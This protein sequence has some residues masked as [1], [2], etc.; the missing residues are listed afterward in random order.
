MKKLLGLLLTGHILYGDIVVSGDD[1]L[2]S[3]DDNDIEII[4]T[5]EH[6][7]EAV[8]A[9]SFEKEVLH[10]YEKSYGFALDS[11]LHLGLLSSHNQIANAFSTQFPLNIQMNYIA[12][13]YMVDYMSTTSWL[14]TL[15]FHESAHNF[16]LNP[17]KNPLSNI[18]HKVVKNIPFTSLF[19]MP[20]FPVPNALE[21]SFMLEGNAVLN[22]S[23]FGNGGR[24][25]NGSLLAMAITQSYAG[26]ITPKRTYNNHLYFPYGAHH[27]IVGGFF[28]L[29]L[30]KKYGV[31]KANKYF[32]NFSGQ[33]LPIQ[34]S[35]IF[36][37]TF[38]HDYAK[39]LADYSTWLQSEYSE[40]SVSSGD[41]I[42]TSQGHTKLN[43]NKDE[44]FFLT[45]D[46]LS[47]PKLHIISKTGAVQKS[48]KDYFFNG[49][50]FKIEDEYF[51]VS[52]NHTEVEKI[53]M[54]LYD[55]KGRAVENSRSKIVQD[56]LSDGRFAYFDVGKSFDQPA[57]Y[58]G[59]S[60]YDYVN[61]SVFVDDSDNIYYF[62]QEGKKRTLYKNKIAIFSIQ[63]WFGFVVDA[64]ED[65]VVFIAN[66]KNGS[67]LYQYNG[68]FSRL[69][70][71]DDIIDAKLLDNQ[72]LLLTTITADGYNYIKT[73]I[74][75]T[76]QAPHE[77]TFFFETAEDFNFKQNEPKQ[78]LKHKP[79][80]SYKNLNYSSLNH[81]L[82]IEEDNVDFSI[83][84]KFADPLGQ[85][86]ANIFI[87]RFDEETLAGVGY[88]NSVYRLSY[89]TNI[90][91]V[92]EKDPLVSSRDFGA[93]L[94][95]NYPLYKAGYQSAD[96]NFNYH[97][98]HDRDAREPLSLSLNFTDVKAF[99]KSM[100]ANAK[101]SVSLF[102]VKERD[103]FIGGASYDFFHDLAYEFYAGAGLKYAYSD[104]NFV[105]AKHG[106][107]IN[108]N[109]FGLS[110]DPSQIVMPSIQV[111]LYAKEVLKG[112][113]S[114]YKVLNFDTYSFTIPLSLRRESIY[115]KYN[116]YDIT[117][118]NDRS[119]SFSEY[120]V[121][122]N[123]DLLL[124]HNNSI[125]LSFEYIYNDD[126][127]DSSRF[128]VLF[129][130]PL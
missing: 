21:S 52:S 120:I 10:N 13:A 43:G 85:N 86:S 26:Y 3:T 29:Y 95:M 123:L 75:R 127:I 97:I 99:G 77:R 9:H 121:G 74:E 54:A 92:L 22:E 27:Y 87:S 71:G 98:D 115:A 88:E 20:I 36:V 8:L 125:P 94:F 7:K 12:G 70:S 33:Y 79:Y 32:W 58:V 117:F 129:D 45:S 48:V 104:T 40:F 25:Y 78:I 124:L 47:K 14:K 89:G 39:E 41:I 42:A 50:V 67:S 49:K 5:Q 80:E 51:T 19:F 66:S 61:S 23:R 4:F 24:L 108:D 130:L 59:D 96:L 103:D 119:N 1:Y 102:A 53:E 35:D 111:D 91:G 112:G 44:V 82:V 110:R 72:N 64:D 2:V 65:G 122:L 17:K 46:A 11:R 57:L 37:Q 84:V 60:F 30:A 76:Q 113:V 93:N 18:A 6:Q 31:D 116:Y 118:L 34:T 69:S 105:D 55:K 101:H 83:G 63:S 56:I 38:G 109:T 100:Y 114:L 106:I 68:K 126:L 16:Q 15:L 81:A 73:K 90:Y 28:Q 107:E 62:K 128:R